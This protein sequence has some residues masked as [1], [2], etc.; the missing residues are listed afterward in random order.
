MSEVPLSEARYY[1]VAEAALILRVK[2]WSVRNHIKSGSLRA[3]KPLGTWL[4]AES[5]LRDLMLANG[6]QA[7]A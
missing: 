1:T 3:T 4:I 5:D 6:N 2:E 7:S